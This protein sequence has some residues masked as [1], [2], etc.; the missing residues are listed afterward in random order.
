MSET[1]NN[2]PWNKDYVGSDGRKEL[3]TPPVS[4][5]DQQ[6]GGS[7]G[8]SGNSNWLWALVAVPAVALIWLF[9]KIKRSL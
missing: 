5:N 7:P 9:S 3:S 4:D 6:S 8:S 1:G 2:K